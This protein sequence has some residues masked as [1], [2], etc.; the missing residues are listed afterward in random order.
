MSL[1]GNSQNTGFGAQNKPS[2]FGGSTTNNQATGGLFG[3]TSSAQQNN[4][5][6]SSLF[7]GNNQQQ[8]GGGLFGNVNQQ[9][10]QQQQQQNAGGSLFGGAVNTQPQGAFNST[11]SLQ[12]GPTQSM[13]GNRVSVEMQ[14]V[15][16]FQKWSLDSPDCA[17][18]YY[19]YNQV[20]TQAVPYYVPG[21]GEDPKAWEEALSKKPNEN[22]IPVLG[23]GF[24][25]VA[26]RLGMQAKAVEALQS[27][28]HEMNDSLTQ[29]LSQHDLVVS[30]R[31]TDARRRHV[32]LT[33]RCLTLAKKAQRARNRG[34]AMD[35]REE[36][37]RK[38]LLELEKKAFDPVL[39]GRTE[40]I[41]ARMSSIRARARVLQEEFQKVGKNASVSDDDELD[42]EQLKAVKK[43]LSDFDSQLT[44]LK[45]ELEQIT[46]EFDEWEGTMKA[47][48]GGR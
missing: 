24:K 30:V 3:S 15:K 38:T 2:L 27:R 7:G 19:F 6:G 13:F 1:F 25:A 34:Y 46:K 22:A 8:Q 32:A 20:P 45:K 10:N 9:N 43:V 17:F 26:E 40:E 35:A 36:Q 48:A 29:M 37:L 18:Q 44:H 39:N 12:P 42:E 5:Q 11:T 47:P 4:N 33:Q 21:P 23:R 31:A 28:L 14:M 16:L 41:W